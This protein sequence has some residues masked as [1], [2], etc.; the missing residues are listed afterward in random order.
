MVAILA[1]GRAYAPRPRAP[2]VRKEMSGCVQGRCVNNGMV[3]HTV[4]VDAESA[5][6]PK[7]IKGA[8]Q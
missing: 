7:R 1:T 5:G 8:G 3:D 2:V 6:V 4:E